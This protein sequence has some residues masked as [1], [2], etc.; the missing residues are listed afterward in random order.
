MH[1]PQCYCLMECEVL[2]G[3]IPPAGIVTGRGSKTATPELTSNS[4]S[5]E[6]LFSAS[7]S[8]VAKVDAAMRDKWNCSIHSLE[9][10]AKLVSLRE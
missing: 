3:G 4:P 2:T 9:R 5:F 6:I 7:C 10:A 1:G 8:R